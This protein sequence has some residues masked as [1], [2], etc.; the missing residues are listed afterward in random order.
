MAFYM[1][2]Q[3]QGR[4]LA[5]PKLRMRA[6]R[7][8]DAG[9]S[10]A[11]VRAADALDHLPRDGMPLVFPITAG[12][13]QLSKH[14]LRCV[15]PRATVNIAAPLAALKLVQAHCNGRVRWE[16]VRSA[17]AAQWSAVSA[18]EFLDGLVRSGALIE[19]ASQL[20]V[21]A[22]LGWVPQ[23]YSAPLTTPQELMDLRDELRRPLSRPSVGIVLRPG[24]TALS[25]ILADRASAQTFGNVPLS[26]QGITD[27]LWALYGTIGARD[28]DVRRTIPSGGG[29][30]G[31]RWYLALMRDTDRCAAGLYKVG[32]HA[33]RSPQGEV[34]LSSLAGAA[35]AAWSSL[36]TP[37]I[38]SHAQAVIYPVADLPSI[39]KKY[40]NRA[41]TLA[42]IEAGHALQNGA[43]AASL[44][45]GASIVRGDTVEAEVQRLFGL[46]PRSYPLPSL[47]I[48]PLATPEQTSLAMAHG[49]RFQLRC[50]PDTSRRLR[51]PTH[52]CVAGPIAV[53]KRPVYRIWA[54][55]RSGNPRLAAI[56]AE[57]EAWERIGWA[58]PS[59]HLVE[60]RLGDV[61]DAVHPGALVAYSESQYR[62]DDFAYRPWS[63][64]HRY[65]WVKGIDVASGRSVSLM[66]QC[67]YALSALRASHVK[68][69]FTNAS[70]S[71]TA[72]WT[73]AEG[74]I[75]RAVVELVERDS[76]ARCWLTREVAPSVALDQLPSSMRL[77]LQALLAAGYALSV[78]L[79]PS[80]YLPVVSVFVQRR[81]SSF[82]AVTTAAGFM[83]EEA[84]DSAL[85]E[86][87]SRVQE[88]HEKPCEL[89]LDPIGVRAAHDHGSFYRS[90]K[91]HR[92]ADFFVKAPRALSSKEVL[93]QQRKFPKD[94]AA[95]L[96]RLRA[97]GLPIYACD[98][99]AP[100]SAIQQGRTPLHVWRA[101]VP[102]LLPLWFG[103][104]CEPYGL[105]EQG[106][107]KLSASPGR[108]RQI[109]A[110]PS[111]IHPCT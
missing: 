52:I 35:D 106:I 100:G 54:A 19:A 107:V 78:Q 80:T 88:Y 36:L 91:N 37:D 62:R 105:L 4:Q 86:T 77:R 93:A 65:P 58:T 51:L 11:E 23:L 94:A 30:Y 24:S 67:V 44:A 6:Q 29:L 41:L 40:G 46:D 7:M 66:A 61:P 87:E 76:F 22:R 16:A 63:D 25:R 5:Q 92:S 71:G 75:G 28:D 99:T 79:L 8:F 39:E 56:K 38:L 48:G 103:H 111:Q 13:W 20:A 83:F 59:P 21:H 74:A 82:T 26:L 3:L 49:R 57:A 108:V 31:I 43:I 27:I 15:L 12:S 102:G 64:K 96:D 1:T 42:M 85:G 101:F 97:D 60:A 14:G 17:L 68:R 32:Y 70:T 104:G 84:L 53:C 110:R 109:V 89:A 50:V 9:D 81:Q 98:V 10:P 2:K 34:S 90:T 47:V 18:D 45:G 33:N 95:L 72:A 69:P 55:G 73:T